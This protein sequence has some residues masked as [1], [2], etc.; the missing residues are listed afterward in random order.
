[1]R[2]IDNLD[3][4][5]ETHPIAALAPGARSRRKASSTCKIKPPATIR[6]RTARRAELNAQAMPIRQ[7]TPIRAR[8]MV[9]RAGGSLMGR[10]LRKSRANGERI[11]CRKMGRSRARLARCIAAARPY[12]SAVPE[13]PTLNKVRATFAFDDPA[14]PLKLRAGGELARFDLAYETYGTLNADKSNA[15]LLF[16][17]LTGS[18]NAMQHTRR[19]SPP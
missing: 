6:Q 15:V 9:R 19:R 14:S 17:A 18:Q 7:A 13:N 5:G 2:A 1:M 12:R 4:P 11:L 16:H 3:E 10:M 8:R